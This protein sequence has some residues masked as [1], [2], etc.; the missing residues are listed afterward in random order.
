MSTTTTRPDSPRPD[1]PRP[2]KPAP[3]SWMRLPDKAAR[4]RM[5]ALS[6]AELT[7]LV[8]NRTALFGALLMPL[9]MVGFLLTMADTLGLDDG[10]LPLAAVLGTSAIG[11]VLLMA[12]YSTLIPAYVGR[13]EERVL[14]RLRTG[15]ATDSQI[16]AGTAVPAVVLSLMQCAVIIVA[17][18]AHPSLS[19]PVR[20]DLLIAGVLLGTLMMTLMAIL[21]S[22]FTRTVESAQITA[23]PLFL[24]AMATS[25]MLT[26]L[27]T[28]PDRMADI[29][30]MLPFTPIMDLVRAG[31][32]D[33]GGGDVTRALLLAVAWT[34]LAGYGIRRWFRWDPRQ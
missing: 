13:R 6:R 24:L 3:T 29:F 28:L 27:D 11:M 4:R 5:A 1:A 31:W 14:K 15:E 25:G 34:V 16:L 18:S 21:T 8:R 32:L 19:T 30:R 33:A 22:A 2:V 20:P 26:Q 23:M 9:L 10:N 12:V 7:L 17:G